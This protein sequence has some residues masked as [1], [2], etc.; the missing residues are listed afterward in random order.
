MLTRI[1]SGERAEEER[2]GR[3]GRDRENDT[4]I[5]WCTTLRIWKEPMMGVP[6]KINRALV[7]SR[8]ALDTN[9]DAFPHLPLGA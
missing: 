4:H 9:R 1:V 3:R 7:A 2:S 6:A 5:T 8:A